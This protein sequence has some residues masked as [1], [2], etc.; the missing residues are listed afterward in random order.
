MVQIWAACRMKATVSS[1]LHEGTSLR[2]LFSKH[3]LA[4]C[5]T[6][7][8]NGLCWNWWSL[9]YSLCRSKKGAFIAQLNFVLPY[10][11]KW[12]KAMKLLYTTIPM[13][14]DLWWR[15]SEHPFAPKAH[16][17]ASKFAQA[18]K[19]VSSRQSPKQKE[20]NSNCFALSLMKE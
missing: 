19:I 6:G 12:R 4:T 9:M 10:S 5:H 13:P 18:I 3:E 11:R 7:I 15:N 1:L 16:L 2:P 8:C 20:S 17:Y 14:A